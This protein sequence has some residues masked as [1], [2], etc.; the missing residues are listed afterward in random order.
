MS[1]ALSDWLQ[2]FLTPDQPAGTSPPSPTPPPAQTD[3]SS[4]SSSYAPGPEEKPL[5][6][7]EPLTLAD[8]QLLSDLFYLP[9]QYGSRA[10]TMLRD[11]DWIRN[12]STDTQTSEWRERAQRFDRRCDA[13]VQM[14]DRLSNAPNRRVLYDLYN[15]ICDIKSAVGLARA[16]VKRLGKGGPACQTLNSDPE[17]WGFRGGLSGEFQRMLPCHGNRDLFRPAPPTT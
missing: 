4:S 1:S 2:E 7:A 8:L 5:F 10:R 14:F 15:Y 6:W 16:H 13:V 17:P 11:L 12:H 3:S 9:Y